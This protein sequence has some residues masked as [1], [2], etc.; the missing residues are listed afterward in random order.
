MTDPTALP[1]ERTTIDAAS[2]LHLLR[3]KATVHLELPD[4]REQR[5]DVLSLDAPRLVVRGALPALAP[6]TPVAVRFAVTGDATY[7]LA[8]T[9]VDVAPGPMHAQVTLQLSDNAERYEMRRQ[10]RVVVRIVARLGRSDQ[11]PEWAH[12][13]ATAHV[14]DISPVGV[15]ILCDAPLERGEI[16]LF[17][18]DLDDAH[19]Q[20]RARVVRIE[21]A[22]PFTRYGL[23]FEMLDATDREVLERFTT[24]HG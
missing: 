19:L 21:S 2:I 23:E 7:R 12:M 8:T 20:C 14:R 15:G 13:W 18:V 16:V 17:D 5:V 10:G 6:E 3:T 9:V 1:D 22:E 11:Y 24:A 4:G